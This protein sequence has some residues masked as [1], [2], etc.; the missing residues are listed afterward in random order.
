[1]KALIGDVEPVAG[2]HT[3]LLLESWYGATCLWHA[4]R[5]RDVL[6]PTGR[7]SNHWLRVMDETAPQGWRWHKLSDDAA[8]VS[9]SDGVQMTWPRGGKKVSVPVVTTSVRTLS[10]CQ[11]VIVRHR[12][13]AL[14][15]HTRSWASSDLETDAEGLLTHSAARW[16]MEVVFGDGKEELGLD[17]SHV[18]STSSLLRLW[19]LAML[20]SVFL[21]EEQQR[22]CVSWQRPV[23]IG[24][25]R[26]EIQRRHRRCLLAW[27]HDQFLSGVSPENVFELFAV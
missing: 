25:A 26:H 18:M 20:A 10:R 15:A 16:E 7:K 9:D 21:E 5:E 3:H 2:T 23:S 13:T 22:V 8:Q 1:M 17:H 14:L 11:V 6:I 19:T 4:A 24:E 12:L 27:L